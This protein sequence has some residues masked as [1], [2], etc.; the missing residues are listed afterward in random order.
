MKTVL[1]HL[2]LNWW[3]FEGLFLLSVFQTMATTVSWAVWSFLT[4]AEWGSRHISLVFWRIWKISSSPGKTTSSSS[5]T[6]LITERTL[7]LINGCGHTMTTYKLWKRYKLYLGISPAGIAHI[8]LITQQMSKTPFPTSYN[9]HAPPSGEIQNE[10][11]KGYI[12]SLVD[13]VFHTVTDEVFYYAYLFKGTSHYLGAPLLKWEC[14]FTWTN[15]GGSCSFRI[16]VLVFMESRPHKM[17]LNMPK[18]QC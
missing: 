1:K 12:L 4:F 14:I 10:W 17:Q 13:K 9:H 11:S 18:T 6:R 15:T 2:N 7:L 16:A 5:F 8:L 3:S